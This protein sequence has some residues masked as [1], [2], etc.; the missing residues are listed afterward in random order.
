MT[1]YFTI[2]RKLPMTPELKQLISDLSLGSQ[3]ESH[4]YDSSKST[5]QHEDSKNHKA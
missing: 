3:E 4:Q 1:T 2:L 5:T